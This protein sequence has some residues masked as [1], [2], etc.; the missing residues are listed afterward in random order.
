MA[1][2]KHHNQSGNKDATTGEV[3]DTLVALAPFSGCCG[4]P[5]GALCKYSATT[6]FTDPV[7]SVTI[8]GTVVAFAAAVSTAA[9]WKAAVRAALVSVGYTDT[10]LSGTRHSTSGSDVT[11]DV[12]TS[13][14][15]DDYTDDQAASVAV[16]ATCTEITVCDFK[17]TA[18]GTLSPVKIGEGVETLANDPYDWTGVGATDDTTAAQLAT[19][20]DA[21]LTSQSADFESVAVAVNNIVEA[22]DITIVAK[23]GLNVKFNGV[24]VE[25][26]DCRVDYE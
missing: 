25:R 21:A 26:D 6:D 20:I 9:T 10:E 2:H 11:L 16:T 15:I 18:V 4:A 7:E 13:G 12:I 23:P 17:L 1:W 8:D 14:V 3:Q 5:D 22:F 24:Q 19:D